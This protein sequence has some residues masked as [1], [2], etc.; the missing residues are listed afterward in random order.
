MKSKSLI[1]IVIA[2]GCGLVAS[3]GISQ[4]MDRGGGQA[5]GETT[6]ILVAL[7]DI[8]IN[9]RIDAQNVKLEDWP[10]DRVPEGAF[11]KFDEVKDLYTRTRFYKGEPIL[12]VKLS[13]SLGNN[14]PIPEGYR[15]VPIT[16]KENLVADQLIQPGDRVDILCFMQ[17]GSEI[18]MTITK[19]VL[20][21]V[22]IWAVN[23]K[24]ERAKQ[25]DN[26][27]IQARTVSVLVKP[28]QV[29][30]LMLAM[31]L[32]KIRLSLRRADD[33]TPVDSKDG[34]SISELISKSGQLATDPAPTNTSTSMMEYLKGKQDNQSAPEPAPKGPVKS[35]VVH[36]PDGVKLYKWNRENELPEV[37]TLGEA[38]APATAPSIATPPAEGTNSGT[39][40]APPDDN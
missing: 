32:G 19:T 11:A 24:T 29:E 33:K 39:A 23:E 20:T 4:I 12:K 25:E 22:R 31:E 18:P 3:I 38:G 26:E 13:N 34:T 40:I 28:E 10:K 1:L 5:Q 37:I 8:N 36:T 6:K 15:V 14:P 7:N 16:V 21:D 2:C 9:D 17:R 35:M 27:S 30:M